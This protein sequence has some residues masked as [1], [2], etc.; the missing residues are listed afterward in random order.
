MLYHLSKWMGYL[1]IDTQFSL[2]P[3]LPV[4]PF[5]F[6]LSKFPPV[7][8]IGRLSMSLFYDMSDGTFISFACSSF[9][10][11]F[12]PSILPSSVCVFIL[13][14]RLCRACFLQIQSTYSFIA[15]S[16]SVFYISKNLPCLYPWPI[17][18]FC[19]GF[20]YRCAHSTTVARS[21]H[22]SGLPSQT[23]W[24]WASWRSFRPCANS[25]R[26]RGRCSERINIVPEMKLKTRCRLPQVW[27]LLSRLI[28]DVI[29]INVVDSYFS[30]IY[31]LSDICLSR[32]L[33]ALG[34]L[35]TEWKTGSSTSKEFANFLLYRTTPWIWS[36]YGLG[37]WSF[38]KRERSKEGREH[39]E[40]VFFNRTFIILSSSWM[41]MWSLRG[42]SRCGIVSSP[43]PGDVG[44]SSRDIT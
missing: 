26:G 28:L 24:K 35:F 7:S 2:L 23:P 27:R 15:P 5:A 38:W 36:N 10:C 4:S 17:A 21:L 8:V 12:L 16:F 18:V 37:H 32:A 13:Y 29:P 39:V 44:L 9:I 43:S 11:F 34:S 31:G 40:V 3:V 1:L 25:F 41:A 42:R 30:N 20:C 6:P 22:N 19:S 14:R 33:N